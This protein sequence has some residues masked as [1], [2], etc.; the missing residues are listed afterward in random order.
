MVKIE[1]EGRRYLA[2]DDNRCVKPDALAGRKYALSRDRVARARGVRSR[3]E[4]TH[5]ATN[6]DA[7]VC[8]IAPVQSRDGQDATADCWAK[9]WKDRHYRW[10][11]EA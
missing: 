7:G 5:Y 9:L 11:G 10:G 6:E 2:A 4:R 8:K 3:N 1:G